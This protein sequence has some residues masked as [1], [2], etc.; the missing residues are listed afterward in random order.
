MGKDIK[1]IN[2]DFNSIK[3]E[4]TAYAKNY[5]P[6]TYNDF[7]SASPGMMFMEMTAYVGDVLSYYTDYAMKE[8]MIQ[9]AQERKNIYALAQ[10]FGYK[11]KISAASI[12]SLDIYMEVPATGIGADSLPDLNYAGILEAG[13]VV[14]GIRGQRFTTLDSL[15]FASE[16]QTNKTEIT[17]SKLDEAGQPTYYLL[18]KRV[19]AQSGEAKVKSVVIAD[20]KKYNKILIDDVNII[21]IDSVVDSSGNIWYE[22]PYLAQDTLFDENVNSPAFDPEL[23]EQSQA[24]PYIMSLRKT[25]RR[26]ITNVTPKNK[27]ELQF[28]AGISS[29]P[30]IEIIPSPSNVGIGLHGTTNKFDQ[31]FDPSNFLHTNTYGQVP[32]NTTLTINYTTGY[33]LSGNVNSDEL[34]TIAD[35]KVI[36]YK[37]DGLTT[38][39]KTEVADSIA[40]SNPHPATGGKSA[41]TIEEIRNNSLAYFA[42]QQR[43]VTRDDYIIRAYS[44]PP[45]FGSISKVCITSDT[46]IDKSTNK[47]MQNPLAMNMYVL[48][49]NANKQLTNLNSTTK[50]NLKTYLSQYRMM[51]DSVNIKNGYIINIG[52]NFSIVVLPGRNSKSVILKCIGALKKKLS[53]DKMQFNQPIITKDLILLLASVDGVQSV[54]GVDITNKWKTSDGYSGNKYD[55]NA[56][57]QNGIIYPSIDPAV[58]EV[59]YPDVD[60]KGEVVTY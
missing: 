55:L 10:S 15:D 48:G 56:A 50:N 49:F 59:K 51:T 47:E 42:T 31:A 2:K 43:A 25:T 17:I 26:F 38:A 7:N 23:S 20:A 40:V 13:L 30:D 36:T 24:T 4:L 45:K 53:I 60:I 3:A 28:G 18:K 32:A 9:Y 6:T 22:V 1:Y 54:M 57:N 27:L 19:N 12:V 46:V 34:T 11:P 14:T 39:L 41:E 37:V 29:D 35:G 21:G 44:M 8:N 58:F 33:G 52:I 5:F 16:S